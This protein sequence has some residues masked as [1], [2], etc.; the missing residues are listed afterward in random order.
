MHAV[1]PF[2]VAIGIIAVKF[3]GN[4]F[5]AGHIAFLE[6]QFLHLVIVPF[7]LADVH[8]HQHLGPVLA[9]GAAGTGIDLDDGA[10]LVL[11][12]AEHVPEFKVF[13]DA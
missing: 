6:V 7:T 5:D 12:P 4:R 1:L 9:F 2:Q 10:Q 3:E 8:P 11:L 13:N